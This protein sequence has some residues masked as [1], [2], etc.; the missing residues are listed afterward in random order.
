V[1]QITEMFDSV[2]EVEDLDGGG[3]VEALFPPRWRCPNRR[4]TGRMLARAGWPRFAD[5]AAVAHG[6]DV[7]REVGVARVCRI[8][9][10]REVWVKSTAE[11]GPRCWGPCR[12]CRR[13]R[14]GGDF[15]ALGGHTG[16]VNLDAHDVDGP[17]GSERLAE[18]R[19][20]SLVSPQPNIPKPVLD[21]TLIK[22]AA[23]YI[24]SEE[25]IGKL[26]E[27]LH[28]PANEST[29]PAM[30]KKHADIERR[31][32]RLTDAHLDGAID[33]ADFKTRKADLVN[34]AGTLTRLIQSEIERNRIREQADDSLRLL[35]TACIGFAR[36]PSCVKSGMRVI[37][38]AISGTVA[39]HRG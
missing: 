4:R 35:V 17:G 26:A 11:L 19:A 7:A 28:A 2:E 8:H 36:L 32:K 15:V 5:R 30:E 23:D 16:T 29:R 18:A 1:V 38:L 24:A 37:P 22:F 31:I 25:V 27:K 33:L 13:S 21:E 6:A 10:S 14:G 3:E 12:D 20:K 39:R 34:E 9:T